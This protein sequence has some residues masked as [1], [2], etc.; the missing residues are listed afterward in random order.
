M[1]YPLGTTYVAWTFC[2]AVLHRGW[3]LVASVYLVVDAGLS[4]ARLVLIGVAQSVTSMLCEL[5]AGVVAD[6]FSR[7]WS[8]AVSHFLMG[9]AMLATALVDGFGPLVLTQMLWGL[10]WT[11][12]SGADVAWITDE[13][14][15]P[16][17]VP[18]VLIRAERAQLVGTVA[19]LAV[20]G[21]LAWLTRRDVAMA[22]SGAAMVLLGLV[23][24]R[25]FRERRFVPARRILWD[26]LALVRARLLTLLA[27]TAVVNGSAGTIGRLYQVRLVGV[28]L[29]ADPVLWFTG[30]GVVMCLAGAAV[31]SVTQRLSIGARAYFSAVA[32]AAFGVAL[33]AVAPDKWTGSVAVVLAGVGFA[34]ARSFGVIWVNSRADSA[35]RATVHSVFAQ[36]DN[37]GAVVVGLAFFLATFR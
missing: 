28:G 29:A 25:R 20:V 35:V 1:P 9:T 33:L 23:V 19:G 2:R 11:F 17:E 14:A 26:G 16:A 22:L 5:P 3:W 24:V 31:L 12:A 13:L 8:L 34:L 10:S 15:D 27:M 32:L 36:A 7:R 30:L 6:A 37:A 4:P 21:G 18:V